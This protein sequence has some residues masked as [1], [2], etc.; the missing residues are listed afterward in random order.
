M[1]WR[2]ILSFIFF[3]IVVGLL[4]LYWFIPFDTTD[5]IS[6]SN[7]YNFSI[8]NESGG[9]QFYSNMRYPTPLISYNIKDCNLQKQDDMKRAFDLI[10]NVT[11]LSFYSVESNEE[12][13]VTCEDTNRIEGGLFVAG[14]GGPTNISQAG[15]FNVILHGKILLIKDSKC[16]NPNIGIH[17]LLHA[18]GFDHSENPNN[19]MYATSNCKQTIGEDIPV[20]IDELYSIETLPDLALFDVSATMRG[21]Y[22]DTNI[23]IKNIGLKKAGSLNLVI[24]ANG[25]KIKEHQLNELDIGYGKLIKFTNILITQINVNE[26]SYSIVADFEELDKIN[27]E[28]VL[29]VSS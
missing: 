2:T 27:N 18:L 4:V 17:E 24:Y 1:E 25:K 10:S 8:G 19:I 13:S 23:T 15:D 21:K 29:E 9:M 12:I 5:F 11:M 14:E 7:D 6:K 20:M 26:L 16:P 3:L 28:F 22:L